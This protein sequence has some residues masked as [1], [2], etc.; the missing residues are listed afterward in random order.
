VQGKKFARVW[1]KKQ[2]TFDCTPSNHVQ[3]KADLIK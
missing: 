1:P 2:G 3:V